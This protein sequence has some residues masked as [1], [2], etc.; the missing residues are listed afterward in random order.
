MLASPPQ[1]PFP[2]NI[3]GAPY[4]PM[5]L[6]RLANADLAIVTDQ[7]LSKTGTFTA[8]KV[9]EIVF[10]RISGAASAL[11]AGGIYPAAAKAGTPLVATAQAFAALTGAGKLVIATLEAILATDAQTATPIFSLTVAS[12]TAC[13]ADVYIYGYPYP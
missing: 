5:L 12:G 2:A 3:S 1:L 7:A 4:S 9:T 11:T 8:Y 13:A 10:R 6:F